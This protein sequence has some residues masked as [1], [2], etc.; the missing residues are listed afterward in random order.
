MSRKAPTIEELYTRKDALKRHRSAALVNEREQFLLHLVRHGTSRINV[1]NVALYLVLAIR[2]LKL[3]S[4]RDIEQQEIEGAIH[5]YWGHRLS[6]R[7][8]FSG[9]HSAY[10]LRYAVTKWLRFHG[11][12]KSVVSPREPFQERLSD[13]TEFMKS[14]PLMS[15]TIDTHRRHALSF[16]RWFS[17][18]KKSLSRASCADSDKFIAAKT[19]AGWAAAT[20]AS[21]AQSVRA[22]F[23][24]AETRGWC[25]PGI[26]E[27]V[28]APRRRTLAT[29]CQGRQWAEV[30][31]LM[32]SIKGKDRA[33]IRA[34]AVVSIIAT[35]AL[36]SSEVARLRESDFDWRTGTLTVRRSKRGP[37]QRHPL[38]PLVR[39]AVLKYIEVRPE[40][41]CEQ[42][43]LTLKT[44]YR[45]ASKRSFYELTSRRLKQIG[46]S[47]GRMGP[48]SIRHARATSLLQEG[49]SIKEIGDFL[50]HR[51]PESSLVYAKFDVELLRP[52][53]EFSLGSLL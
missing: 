9:C 53:A 19:S 21:T 45:G 17:T 16:L 29:P 4:L 7:S 1:Q 20:L 14:M 51:N 50:G 34:K 26:A 6:P 47:R 35:Y 27:S 5:Q 43:F 31:R 49:A 38:N 46:I 41:S 18:H 32:D 10:R 25:R 39:R 42:L 12:L 52:V 3:E 15:S 13:F 37:F 24:Y 11:R 28:T 2:V 36:R 44:P 33:S 30:R 48:H 8:C 23:R 22:F 40:C